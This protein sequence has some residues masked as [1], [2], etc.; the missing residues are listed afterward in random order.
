MRQH[1]DPHRRLVAAV[2]AGAVEDLKLRG[3]RRREAAEWLASRKGA[4]WMSLLGLEPE[5]VCDSLRR[6]G[7][8]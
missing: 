2:V 8:L 6:Q 7:K 5:A 4:W 3:A 1:R